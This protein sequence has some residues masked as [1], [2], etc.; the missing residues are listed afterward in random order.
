MIEIEKVG[1][2]RN[3]RNDINDDFWGN[4]ESFIELEKHLP[5]SSFEGIDEFS[6]VT[7]V[8]YMHKVLNERICIDS[9]Y[10]RNNSSLDKVGIFAQRGKNRPNKIGVTTCEIVGVNQN[11]LH[12]KGL[13]AINNS[14]VLDIKPLFKKFTINE[15]DIQEARWVDDVMKNYYE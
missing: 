2:V 7:V 6:H 3:N 5:V 1:I 14:P 13:D 9:R 15:K 10:P 11:I 4:V 12:V 8:F